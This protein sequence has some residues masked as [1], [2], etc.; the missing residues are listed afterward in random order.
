LVSAFWTFNKY[1]YYL[2]L[3]NVLTNM[4]SQWAM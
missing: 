4:N 2:T 1:Y 3:I